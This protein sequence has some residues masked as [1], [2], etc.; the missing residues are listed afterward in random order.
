MDFFQWKKTYLVGIEEIDE[1]HMEI[2]SRINQ[3]HGAVSEKKTHKEISTMLNGLTCFTLHHL[4]TEE[5]L[6]IDHNYPLT[7][8]HKREHQH[9]VNEVV[10]FNQNY[11]TNPK[12]MRSDVLNFL[13]NW[14]KHHI[15]DTDKKLGLYLKE[16]GKGA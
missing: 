5:S 11:E 9:L 4:D 13:K 16:K 12:L 1:Q 6:M 8:E 15:M 14:V 3:L 2:F 7:D 10:E